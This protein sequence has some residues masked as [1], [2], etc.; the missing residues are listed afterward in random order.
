MRAR[1]VHEWARSID[2]LINSNVFDTYSHDSSDSGKAS[3]SS[4]D[5]HS[6]GLADGRP[7]RKLN[8]F[9]LAKITFLIARA[10]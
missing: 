8:S 2:A 1:L 3:R 6:A 5:V 4:F 9:H 10:D 7:I